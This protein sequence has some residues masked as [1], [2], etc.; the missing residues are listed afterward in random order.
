MTID[1]GSEALFRSA[2]IGLLEIKDSDIRILTFEQARDA[3]DKGIHIGGVMSDAMGDNPPY[4]FEPIDD[5]GHPRKPGKYGCFGIVHAVRN[6]DR[7]TRRGSRI[8]L[9]VT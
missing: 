2:L 4:Q 8:M 6:L 9:I 7:L 1:N 3:A 5:P